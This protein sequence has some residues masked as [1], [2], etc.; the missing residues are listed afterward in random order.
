MSLI[1][2]PLG[3][4]VPLELY[5]D[6]LDT[7]T[8]NTQYSVG[9]LRNG[10]NDNSVDEGQERSAVGDLFDATPLVILVRAHLDSVRRLLR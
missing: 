3:R 10:L 8:Q 5:E 6:R 2:D 4:T 7:T 1:I 9:T